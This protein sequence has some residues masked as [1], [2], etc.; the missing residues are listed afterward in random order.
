MRGAKTVRTGVA[1]MGFALAACAGPT[2]QVDRV[3]GFANGQAVLTSAD[4]RLVNRT[5]PGAGS[6]HGR[7]V[8]ATIVCAEPSPD[9]ARALSNSSN[10]GLS[11]AL[12]GLQGLSP[13]AAVQ[14][15]AAIARSQAQTAAQLGERLATIQIL[16][17][18]LYRACEAYANGALS[19]VSYAAILAGYP[20][21]SVS[22]LQTEIAGGAFGRKLFAGTTEAAGGGSSAADISAS[23]SRKALMKSALSTSDIRRLEGDLASAADA[24]RDTQAQI[25]AETANPAPDPQR[26]ATLNRQLK[27]DTQQTLDT[28][29]NLTA[30][31][32]SAAE[33][34]AAAAV[35]PDIGTITARQNP[36]IARSI[37]E[38]NAR[39]L[40]NAPIGA[41]YLPCIVALSDSQPSDL[42]T[43]C[44]GLIAKVAEARVAA[45]KMALRQIEAMS[46]QAAAASRPE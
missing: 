2:G 6:V 5:M 4:V 38:M 37:V 34:T 20:D 45:A 3:V 17:D 26:L 46:S 31:L 29:S 18:A 8:P 14:V 32:K 25:D 24:V 41:I 43:E 40:A 23:D 1:L 12:Q 11:G 10:F 22:M 30:S 21:T 39:F 28:V 16:R 13:E 15:A 19:D 33:A 44:R 36:E 35:A 27:R 9:L 42:D 7:V